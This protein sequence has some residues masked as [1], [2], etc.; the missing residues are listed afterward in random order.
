[1]LWVVSEGLIS[2][3]KGEV[4]NT[5]QRHKIKWVKKMFAPERADKTFIIS[6]YINTSNGPSTICLFAVYKR[7]VF[8]TWDDLFWYAL[9]SFA[10]PIFATLPYLEDVCSDEK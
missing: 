3:A 10:W 4:V 2:V 6:S 8:P 7:L 5:H 9:R 1:M